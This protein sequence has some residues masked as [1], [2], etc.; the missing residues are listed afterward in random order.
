LEE[1]NDILADGFKFIQ[2]EYGRYKLVRNKAK[3]LDYLKM[4]QNGQKKEADIKYADIDF[5]K[6]AIIDYIPPSHKYLVRRKNAVANILQPTASNYTNE[7]NQDRTLI[8]KAPLQKLTGLVKFTKDKSDWF[9]IWDGRKIAPYNKETIKDN[10]IAMRPQIDEIF[11][12]KARDAII[13]LYD[14]RGMFFTNLITQK[15]FEHELARIRK[16]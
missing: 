14:A 15:R 9:C 7:F 8:T 3:L 16:V 4:C 13:A 2:E 11:N 1:A 6:R 10:I 12:P 5:G